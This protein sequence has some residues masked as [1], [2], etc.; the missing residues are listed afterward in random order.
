MDNIIAMSP[1]FVQAIG[2]TLYMTII[3]TLV[4]YAIG[5]PVGF[6][7]VVSAPDGIHPMPGANRIIGGIVNILR[8]IPFLILLVALKGFTRFVVGTSIGPTAMIVPLVVSSAP[9]IARMVESSAKEVDRGVIEA[10]QSMGASPL[11]IIRKVILPE[12]KP[13]L[14]VGAAITVTLVLGYSAMAGI[15]AGG[16]LGGIAINYGYYRSQTDVMLVM[17]VLLVILVQIFQAIGDTVAL[18][19]DKRIR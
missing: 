14:I 6:F 19:F 4:A 11:Q 1:L 15:V 16:G 2:E 13:S 3:S 10:S 9:Y 7:L 18:K 5:M 12:A 17:I 8:S